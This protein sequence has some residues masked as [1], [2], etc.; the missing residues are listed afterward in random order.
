VAAAVP[1]AGLTAWQA[2]FEAPSG[3]RGAGLRAGQSVLIHAA[4][5]GVGSFAVQLAKWKGA[6]VVG[7][8]SANHVEY[9]RSIGADDVIDYT[10]TRFEDAARDLDVVVDLVGG[11]TLARSWNVLRKD[12]ILVSVVSPPSENEAVKRGVRAGYVFVQPSALQLDELATLID[13]G[14]IRVDVSHVLPLALASEAH[15]RSEARHVRGKIVLKVR[16]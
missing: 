7:T 3:Y 12:G 16:D 6:R 2:L 5:G 9:V 15:A 11:D 1:L 13:A 4:A 14:T 8:C 10:S